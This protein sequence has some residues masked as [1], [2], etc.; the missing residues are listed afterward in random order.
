MAAQC[1][2]SSNI[3]SQVYSGQLYTKWRPSNIEGQVYSG[4]L[5]TLWRPSV[6]ISSNIDGQVYSGQLYTQWRHSLRYHLTLKVKSIQVNSIHYGG[7]VLD[8]I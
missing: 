1:Y 7:P 3:E 8:F 2:I 4:Q 6:K 5:Y